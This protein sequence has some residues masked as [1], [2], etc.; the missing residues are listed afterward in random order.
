MR[1]EIILLWTRFSAQGP[2][3]PPGPPNNFG[4]FGILNN[5]GWGWDGGWGRAARGRGLRGSLEA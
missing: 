1:Y 2:P 4:V 3:P 5:V